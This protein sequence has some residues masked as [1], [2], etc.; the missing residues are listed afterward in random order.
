MFSSK[1]K[2]QKLSTNLRLAIN[3]L[4]LLEKKKTELAVKARKEIADYLQV[5]KID[6][7]RI[8]VESIVREDYLVEAMEIVEMYCDLLL[9]RMG[10][11]QSMKE[12]DDGLEEPIASIIWATPRLQ[13]ECQE[14]KVISEQLGLKYG[15]EFLLSCQR[16]ELNNVNEKL[17]H[18]LGV[19]APPR[20]L[21]EK[22]LE[23]I[24]KSFSVSYIPEVDGDLDAMAADGLLI[25]FVDRK[26]GGSGGMVDQQPTAPHP[27]YPYQP[28]AYTQQQA[29]YQQQSPYGQV[30]QAPAYQT[31]HAGAAGGHS[32]PY[33][34]DRSSF[35]MPSPAGNSA[36]AAP[37]DD[38]N[39]YEKLPDLPSVPSGNSLRPD[40]SANDV[41]FDDLTK[42][43]EELKKRK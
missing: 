25:D 28:G 29:P 12:L 36:A 16:N 30:P 6:R 41:D 23:E 8:R 42:R 5:S 43:F 22:Y 32:A 4:K 11:I 19:Q 9:A 17:I 18:K 21:V 35:P 14:L 15:K 33:P 38:K 37:S 1:P 10:L 40:G 24:A 26:N 13:G 3:R 27:G 2:Y 31:P 39:A 34:T 7:A 20:M